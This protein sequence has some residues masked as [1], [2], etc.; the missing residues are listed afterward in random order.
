MSTQTTNFGLV[1]PEMGDAADI[2]AMNPNWDTIDAKLKEH[3]ALPK[4]A[5]KITTYSDITQIGLVNGS[6][7]I[8]TIASALPVNSMLYHTV[9]EG[10]NL[11]EYPN[12]NYGLLVVDKTLNSRVVFTY[13][14]ANGAQY[15]GYCTITIN[16]TVW[17]G[18]RKTYNSEDMMSGTTDLVANSTALQSGKLYFVYE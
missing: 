9:A 13:T 16:G 6:E 8:A 18:W 5:P 3:D 15:V 1:K 4:E 10:S 17:T 7:T 11:T 2:T 12:S 14:I